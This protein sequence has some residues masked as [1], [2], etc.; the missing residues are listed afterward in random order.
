M[1]IASISDIKN[2]TMLCIYPNIRYI[3]SYSNS[4]A[5]FINNITFNGVSTTFEDNQFVFKVNNIQFTNLDLMIILHDDFWTTESLITHMG[6]NL[7]PAPI[8]HGALL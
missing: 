1:E 2:K 5:N 4:I 8:V 6:Y 7:R 3:L